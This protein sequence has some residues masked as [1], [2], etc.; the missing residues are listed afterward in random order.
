MI[1]GNILRVLIFFFGVIIYNKTACFTLSLSV[2]RARKGTREYFFISS[3]S[4]DKIAAVSQTAFSNAFSSMKQCEF[5]LKFHCNLFLRVQLTITQIDNSLAP[6]RRQAF[7]WTHKCGTSWRSLAPGY[8]AVID[9]FQ[10][11][12]KERYLQFFLCNR[13]QVN[14]WRP[15]W[16][17]ICIDSGNGLVASG[18]KPLSE[19]MLIYIYVAIWRH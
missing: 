17:S 1:Y 8:E 15:T 6:N 9:N 5:W 16:W 14:A 19:P 11:H 10:T 7:V 3:L 13:P 2:W 4:L 18:N 12:I